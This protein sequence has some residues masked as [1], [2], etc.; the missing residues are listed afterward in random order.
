MQSALDSLHMGHAPY[1]LGTLCLA[2]IGDSC[3][4]IGAHQSVSVVH[5]TPL[6]S[7]TGGLRR[8]KGTSTVRPNKRQPEHGLFKQGCVVLLGT[9]CLVVLR[10]KTNGTPPF[11]GSPKQDTATNTQ[12][13]IPSPG[14]SPEPVKAL[15]PLKGHA[16]GPYRP[17]KCERQKHDQP[18]SNPS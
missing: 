9:P 8:R 16:M 6:W 18:L 12:E 4:S 15:E 10:K 14:T 2:S 7:H 3:L 13:G 1:I 5:N 11:W 17:S